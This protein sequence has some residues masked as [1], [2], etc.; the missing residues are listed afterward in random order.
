M[1]LVAMAL[2][3]FV[4]ANDFTALNVALPAIEQDFDVDVDSVQWVINAYALVF[5]M[6]IVSGGRLADMFGRRR[7]FFIGSILFAAFSADRR[8]RSRSAGPDRRPCRDGGRRSADVAGDPRDDVRGAA[9]QSKAGLAGGLIL[10]VAGI[11]NAVGPLLGGILTEAIDWRAIFVLNI[12]VAAFA[13]FVT[14]RKVHQ[15]QELATE[16]IDYAGMATISGGLVLLLLALDQSVDWGW[17]DPRVI[18]MLAV[19]IL[20][21]A[22]FTRIE[23]RAGA[24]ALIP[25]DVIANKRF[26]SA[27]LVVL[28]MSAVFFSAVLYIPQF[29]EKILGYTAVEAGLGDAADDG[30]VRAHLV[31][32]RAALRPDRDEGRDRGRHRPDRPRPAPTRPHDRPRRRDREPG[33]RTA[34]RRASASACSI[35]R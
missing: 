35:R 24:N 26:R 7:I 10:G 17:G 31:P 8:R 2:G 11:G 4:I 34:G 1:A 33:S 30:R 18:A 15:E 12:P 27:C 9:R 3:V 23:R 25:P 32:R 20:L 16:R 14:Y 19:A 28:L 21:V 13:M 6:A 22:S 5:G 29:A